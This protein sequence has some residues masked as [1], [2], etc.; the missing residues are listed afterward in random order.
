MRDQKLSQAGMKASL[1]R[2]VKAQCAILFSGKLYW[3]H[4]LAAA[5]SFLQLFIAFKQLAAT[6]SRY[7]AFYLAIAYICVL[8]LVYT[9]LLLV[10][11]LA[12]SR[13]SAWLMWI[14]FALNYLSWGLI[15]TTLLYLVAM[16]I[17]QPPNF[18]QVYVAVQT[19]LLESTWLFFSLYYFFDLYYQQRQFKRYQYKLKEKLEAENKFLKSQ[20]NP[21]FLFNTLNNIYSKTLSHSGESTAVIHQLRNL[22]SYM[23]Y[24]CEQDYVPLKGE[25]DFI[26]SYIA[27]EQIRNKSTRL[28]VNTEVS[29]TIGDQRIAPLL[30]VNF[31][32][33]AFKHGVKSSIEAAFIDLEFT[34]I[35]NVFTMKLTNSVPEKVDHAF[36]IREEGGI[37]IANVSKRLQLLYPK[38]HRLQMSSTDNTYTTELSLQLYSI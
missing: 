21:H 29:G 31:V 35:G 26:K 1:G 32:E 22:L 11:P 33:N 24:D 27:L 37:G 12:R 14:G 19:T 30:I 23:L 38:M 6:I 20:I 10:I 9:F 7:N 25:L 28:T 36:G 34:I 3:L 17:G 4:I 8:G 5:I 15:L 18:M 2:E 16:L 13:R